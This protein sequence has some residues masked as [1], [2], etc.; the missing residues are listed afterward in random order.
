MRDGLDR[1]DRG[2]EVRGESENDTEHGE[3]ESRMNSPLVDATHL[4]G[5][6]VVMSWMPLRILGIFLFANAVSIPRSPPFSDIRHHERAED[7]VMN[8]A[9]TVRTMDNEL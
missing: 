6:C 5:M 3:C 4:V 8:D 7:N 2:S 1:E 9:E